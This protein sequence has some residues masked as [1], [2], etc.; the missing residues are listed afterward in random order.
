[1]AKSPSRRVTNDS[2]VVAGAQLDVEKDSFAKIAPRD[3]SLVDRRTSTA[4][5]VDTALGCEF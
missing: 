5:R 1:M 2:P 3:T 4:Y